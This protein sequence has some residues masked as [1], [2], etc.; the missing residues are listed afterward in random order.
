ML[1]AAQ[2]KN[3]KADGGRRKK[4]SDGR[5]LILIVDPS[6]G[7]WWRYRYKFKGRDRLMSLGTFPTMS[8]SQARIARDQAA[9]IRAAGSD[10]MEGAASESSDTVEKLAKDWFDAR[11][12]NWTAQNAAR[13]WSRIKNNVLPLLGHR[14]PD[15]LEPKDILDALRPMEARGAIESAHRVRGYIS[16]MCRY[17]IA[18]GRVSRDPAADVRDALKIAPST[19]HFSAITD[20]DT[21]AVMLR[22]IH[23]YKGRW[24]AVPPA[25]RLTPYLLVRPGT[26]RRMEWS[27]VDLDNAEWQTKSLKG[28]KLETLVPLP[29]QAVDELAKLKPWSGDGRYV[30][31]GPRSATR[32]LSENAILQALRGMGWG[33]NEVTA[34]GFRATARTM[35]DEFLQWRVDWIETQLGHNVRDPN[36]R[37]YNR[38][39]FLDERRAMMQAWADYL[40]ALRIAG[41]SVDPSPHR[42]AAVLRDRA[43]V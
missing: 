13:V 16:S 2:V 25:V 12:T 23:A 40:D 6:G 39:K 29:A 18:S 11:S 38:T 34:H 28:Q 9:I 7:K 5:G 3:A 20:P 22:D 35:L 32:P 14:D 41:R 30:F 31:P 15:S 27:D 24:W 26:L 43:S 10:P 42:Q 4:L 33:K 8:L 19:V 21:L 1:T 37:A 36:G 17:G